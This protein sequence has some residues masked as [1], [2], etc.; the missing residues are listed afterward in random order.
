MYHVTSKYI[1]LMRLFRVIHLQS[2]GLIKHIHDVINLLYYEHWTEKQNYT[3]YICVKDKVLKS[4]RGKMTTWTH[5][6]C[7]V[8]GISP[9]YIKSCWQSCF[10]YVYTHTHTHT[11]THKH[12]HTHRQAHTLNRMFHFSSYNPAKATFSTAVI[13]MAHR[14]C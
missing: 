7:D 11:H 10:I 4:C 9:L 6:V 5:N 2:F 14:S 13:D 12:W 3:P 1:C 8:H